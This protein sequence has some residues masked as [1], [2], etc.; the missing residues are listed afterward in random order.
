MRGD[1]QLQLDRREEFL[2]ETAVT[3]VDAADERADALSWFDNEAKR[4]IEALPRPRLMHVTASHRS[5]LRVLRVPRRKRDRWNSTNLALAGGLSLFACGVVVGA[6][7]GRPARPPETPV[8]AAPSERLARASTTP[9]ATAPIVALDEGR[10]TAGSDIAQTVDAGTGAEALSERPSRAAAPPHRGTL[11]VTSI[12]RGAAVFL[13]DAYAGETPLTM[14]GIAS[15]SRAVRVALDGY[16]VWSRG[17]QVVADHATTVSA[18]L[19]RL[20][21]AE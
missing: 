2:V 5:S 1:Q 11:I 20:S 8:D 6:M 10:G 7:L 15:G 13:N 14:R 18:T 3:I 16:G 4:D 12:P 9:A 19:N 17:I 21:R